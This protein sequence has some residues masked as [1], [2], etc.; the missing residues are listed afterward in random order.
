MLTLKLL[1]VPAFLL[2]LSLAGRRWGAAVSGWLAGL[3]VVVG[4]ILLFLA[5]ERGNGFAAAAANSSLAAVVANVAFFATYAR[6][7]Q[8]HPW[9]Q[10]LPI[11]FVAWLVAACAMWSLPATTLVSTIAATAVLLIGPRCFPGVS[12]KPAVAPPNGVPGATPFPYAELAARMLA[13][14]LLVLAVTGAAGV[15]GNAWSGLLAAFPVVG[16]VLSVF[17]HRAQGAAYTAALLRAMTTA[18]P[19][20]A[21]FCLAVALLLPRTGIAPSFMVALV[22]ALAAHAL[23]RRLALPAPPLA[24]EPVQAAEAGS[25]R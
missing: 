4:P 9:P 23:I 5:I 14:A 19:S 24:D 12:A 3:P 21:V 15:L 13:G 8:R 22:V 10:A 11:A 2:L 7:A 16:G 1:L 6:T 17:S 25:P 18:L 20:L